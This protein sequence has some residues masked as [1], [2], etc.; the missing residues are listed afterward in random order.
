MSG[1]GVAQAPGCLEPFRR[2]RRWQ[3]HVEDH[4]L[5]V[6]PCREDQ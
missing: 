5:R 3:T 2:V 1:Q 4:D 6:G